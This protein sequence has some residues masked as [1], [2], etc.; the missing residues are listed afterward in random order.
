MSQ[1]QPPKCKT[2]ATL[3]RLQGLG[4][5]TPPSASLALFLGSGRFHL[6]SRARRCHLRDCVCRSHR[7]TMLCIAFVNS[8][9]LCKIGSK[10]APTCCNWQHLVCTS[11]RKRPRNLLWQYNR[12]KYEP[13]HANL[14]MLT[15]DAISR[16][17]V[18]LILATSFCA[19]ICLW[20]ENAHA[21]GLEGGRLAKCRGDVPC[22]STSSVGNPS[23]FGPP[24]SYQPQTDDA[25]LAW[26]SLK[27]AIQSNK[28]NGIIVESMDGPNDYYLRAEFPSTWKGIDDIE[29][30][31]LKSDALVTYRSA[32]RE[33]I[34]IYPLQTP[35]NTNKNKTRLEQIRQSL[36]W[37]E[38]AGNE[39]YISEQ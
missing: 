31:L 37:E 24:W 19:S 33:A 29:F 14:F 8:T 39:L 1:A 36:G 4:R 9:P 15:T 3:G 2:W 35:I 5:S 18:S 12:P 16:K 32:S 27:R 34:F 10:L 26:Q 25:D 28:D 6:R 23:K 17:V 22:I 20:G 30:R 38:F 21:Y 11:S 13:H 7:S